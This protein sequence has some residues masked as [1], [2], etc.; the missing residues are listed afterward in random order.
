M[1]YVLSRYTDIHNPRQYKV[2]EYGNFM[3]L[4]CYHGADMLG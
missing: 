2:S 1:T 4:T 3:I